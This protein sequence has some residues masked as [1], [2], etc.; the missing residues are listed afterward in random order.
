M[1]VIN[2][3]FDPSNYD[4]MRKFT[5]VPNGDYVAKIVAS[6]YKPTKAKNGHYVEFVFEIMSGEF[7]KKQ[8]WRRL[9]VDNQSETTC[10]IAFEE[11]ATI[12]RAIG[13]TH[14]FMETN[15][16]HGKPMVITTTIEPAQGKYSEFNGITGYAA[17]PGAI[18]LPAVGDSAKTV[19]APLPD[20]PH[21]ENDTNR[22][23]WAT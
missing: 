6:A 7:S 2:K 3:T 8:I 17:V 16:Y 4:S 9:S 13:M 11:L 23:P 18:N 12:A 19:S 14:G 20:A 5:P 21:E 22:P 15:N 1:A 10:K